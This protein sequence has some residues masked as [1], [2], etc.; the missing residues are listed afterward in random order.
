MIVLLSALRLASLRLGGLLY[1]LCIYV[2]R[3]RKLLLSLPSSR[4]SLLL[5]FIRVF[6]L[7][8]FSF[9]QKKHENST[10]TTSEMLR[11]SSPSGY[12]PGVRG[13]FR[14]YRSL[15]ILFYVLLSSRLHFTGLHQHKSRTEILVR[16]RRSQ[17]FSFFSIFLSFP[18]S[19]CFLFFFSFFFCYGTN[20]YAFTSE[21]FFSLLFFCF[22]VFFLVHFVSRSAP[23]A[24]IGVEGTRKN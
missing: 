24:C 15:I 7:K 23:R 6:V 10:T 3:G 17:L 5:L 1:Y 21:M 20:V 9:A 4:N 16:C 18:F 11:F 2:L 13:G 19:A 22:G 14:L 12:V 8:H